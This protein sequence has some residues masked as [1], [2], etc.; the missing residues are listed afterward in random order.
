MPQSSYIEPTGFTSKVFNFDAVTNIN[1]DCI[2]VV[3]PHQIIGGTSDVRIAM[4]VRYNDASLDVLNGSMASG[5]P[6]LIAGPLN[7]LTSNL[8]EV[9]CRNV[10][11]SVKPILSFTDL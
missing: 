2:L 5:G 11:V 9:F 3:H 1:G 8:G 10:C 6:S 4:V 7:A